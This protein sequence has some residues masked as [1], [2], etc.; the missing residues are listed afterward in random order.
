MIYGKLGNEK[1]R[2]RRRLRWF[3]DVK[4]DGLKRIDMSTRRSRGQV[5]EDWKELLRGPEPFPGLSFK[6]D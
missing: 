4:G 1:R 2:G 3:E 6:K 5:R